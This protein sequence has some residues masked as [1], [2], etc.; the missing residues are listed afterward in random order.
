MKKRLLTLLLAAGLGLAATAQAQIVLA[1]WD[2]E[3]GGGRE[4][5]ASPLDALPA[6]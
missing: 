1:G 6:E 2:F 3:Q 4:R 5:P